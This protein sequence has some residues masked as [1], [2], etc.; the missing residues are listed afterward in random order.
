MPLTL[1]FTS[2]LLGPGAFILAKLLEPIV[3]EGIT[4]RNTSIRIINE[5]ASEQI[6][7]FAIKLALGRDYLLEL[8]EQSDQSSLSRAMFGGAVAAV[9]IYARTGDQELG[10]KQGKIDVHGV[11]SCLEQA[12]MSKE[13]CWRWDS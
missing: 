1:P 2:Y 12:C 3:F 10:S 8:C 4:G 6:K 13:M 11:A 5:D 9:I 7:E